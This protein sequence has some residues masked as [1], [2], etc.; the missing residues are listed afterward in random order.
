[1]CIRDSAKA[2]ANEDFIVPEA[3]FTAPDGK[4]FDY[5]QLDNEKLLPG[6]KIV[7]DK[8]IELTAMWYD[9]SLNTKN[10]SEPILEEIKS[11]DPSY[12][13]E[14]CKHSI[15]YKPSD[16][17]YLD[18]IREIS[19]KRKSGEINNYIFT[20]EEGQDMKGQD[21]LNLVFTNKTFFERDDEIIIS[22]R[23][24]KDLRLHVV[25]SDD[26]V[27]NA[28]YIIEIESKIKFET[29]GGTVIED[30]TVRVGSSSI[31]GLVK[32]NPNPS[33]EGNKFIGWYKDKECTEI[34]DFDSE[35]PIT[36]L[37]YTSRCV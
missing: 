21:I 25:S 10:P 15:A 2:Y 28:L 27:M 20:Q 3:K 17:E 7:L 6:Q 34:F 30:Q 19:I 11:E 37:L 5:W 22:A 35:R 14:N 36:C 8:N 31:T 29:F 33:K 18:A 24:Y 26:Y 4:V 16:R 23:G 1:M 13:K 32:P 12:K 9:L